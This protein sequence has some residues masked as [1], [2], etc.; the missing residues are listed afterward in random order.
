MVLLGLLLVILL[1]ILLLQH[2]LY[3]S[4]PGICGKCLGIG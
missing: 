3:R 1:V 2:L 4:V